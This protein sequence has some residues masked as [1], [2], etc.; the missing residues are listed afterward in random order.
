MTHG[1][2]DWC[3]VSCATGFAHRVLQ[4]GIVG[5][6]L[7]ITGCG[8]S[9]ETSQVSS[10]P[11]GSA[12]STDVAMAD[13]S[14]SES[15]MRSSEMSDSTM[16]QSMEHG[17]PE[18]SGDMTQT[19]GDTA[20]VSDISDSERAA[21]TATSDPES[22]PALSSSQASSDAERAAMFAS[23]DPAA[24]TATDPGAETAARSEAMLAGE[25]GSPGAGNAGA[26]AERAAFAAD[27]G[28]SSADGSAGRD[29]AGSAPEPPADSPDYPAFKVVMG[30]MQGN[31]ESLKEFVS[32]T[33]RG[34]IEK[35][36]SGSLTTDEK[37]DLKKTFAQPKLVGQPRTINGSRTVTLNSG[38]QVI[39]IVSKKQGADWKVSSI[40]IKAARKR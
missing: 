23:T 19:A 12:G 25:S 27:A 5:C 7:L 29:G 9:S 33:G 3:N 30:L 24:S 15:M 31:D 17:S 14:M 36:R 32:T 21:M 13:P 4:L 6:G 37:D 39:S 18:A 20:S 26:D 22:D 1:T 34:L 11:A 40:T 16:D 38:D 8:G 2:L 35:I 28:E 10:E